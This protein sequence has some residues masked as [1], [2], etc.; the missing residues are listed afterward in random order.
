MVAERVVLLGVEHLEQGRRRIA[1]EVGAELVDLIEQDDRIARARPAQAL[2][3]PARHGADVGAAVAA[4][5]GLVPHAAQRGARELAPHRARDRAAKRRL[6]DAGRTHEAQDRRLRLGRELAHGEELEDALLHALEPVVVGIEHAARLGQVELVLGLDA[7]GQL[8]HPLEVGA[9]QVSVGRVLRQRGQPLELPVGLCQR[10]L[11]QIRGVDLLAQLVHLA[12]PRVALPELLLD[13]AH[14][15]AQHALAALGIHLLRV[16]LAAQLALRLGDRHLPIEV[17][18]D[19]PQPVARA[20]VL[21]QPDL[22]VRRQRQVRCDQVGEQARLGDA[23][24][25][26]LPLLGHVFAQLDHTLRQLH[27][28]APNG[29]G[30]A[31]RVALF[32]DRLVGHVERGLVAGRSP[33][34]RAC[35]THDQGL[36]AASH[37]RGHAQHAHDGGNRVDVVERGMLDGRVA[38]RHDQQEALLP[39]GLERGERLRAPD[40][41]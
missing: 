35:H 17:A 2:Q 5:L 25:E 21:E 3:E 38:L 39:R 14:P 37:C 18:L 7:P 15:A 19:L 22:L 23:G 4:D 9:D 41:Q 6:A 40:G 28:P 29:L 32:D 27:H 26:R 33:D 31:R 10:L 16:G 12:Q 11:G 30:L 20:R 1:A 36:L 13:L 34:A 8:R 24:D